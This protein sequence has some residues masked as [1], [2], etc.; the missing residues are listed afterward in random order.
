MPVAWEC[1]CLSSSRRWR[2][3]TVLGSLTAADE[4]HQ[5]L[6]QRPVLWG[7]PGGRP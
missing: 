3:K 2:L 1:I 7:R 4:G 5:V 6:R